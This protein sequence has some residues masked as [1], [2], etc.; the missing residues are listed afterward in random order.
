MQLWN[1][2]GLDVINAHERDPAQYLAGIRDGVQAVQ[3]G[4]IELGPLL[5]HRYPLDQ[6]ARALDAMRT[7]PAGFLKAV[8]LT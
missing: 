7:R 3:D 2:R 1:W 4:R 5:T 8:V 6:M